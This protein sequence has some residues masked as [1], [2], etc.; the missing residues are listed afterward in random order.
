[1]KR[2]EFLA[3]AGALGFCPGLSFGQGETSGYADM[4]GLVRTV[5]PGYAE[6]ASLEAELAKRGL[7]AADIEGIMGGNYIRV[8]RQAMTL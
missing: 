3:A 5:M 6:F 2:R 8:L 1:M 7:K 4:H